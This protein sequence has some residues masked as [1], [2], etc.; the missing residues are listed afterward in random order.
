MVNIVKFWVGNKT[1]GA[2]IHLIVVL[3]SYKNWPMPTDGNFLL[4]FF[5]QN[6]EAV[7]VFKH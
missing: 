7:W 5:F 4:M 1:K 3:A 2:G 6:G